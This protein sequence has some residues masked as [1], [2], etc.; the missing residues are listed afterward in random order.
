MNKTKAQKKLTESLSKIDSILA[1][2]DSYPNLED[3]ALSKVQG[4]AN[5][6]LGK[7]FPTQLD[8]AKEILEH[9]VGT[10]V[11]IKIVSEFLV[12]ALPEVEVA[13]KAALLANMNNLGNGCTIDPFIYEKAIKEGIVFDLKQIDL[14]DK[15]S[16]SPLDKKL[17]QYY[18][19]GIE[20][21]ES[22]YDI[23][24]SAIDPNNQ[25]DSSKKTKEG[26]SYLNRAMT[27]S[28]GHYF[29][30]RKRD[31][32]CLLWYMKNKAAYREVWGK[33]TSKS[34]DIFNGG[35]TIT[36][37]LKE[38]GNKETTYY[39]V[40]EKGKLTVWSYGSSW[41]SK[42][43]GSAIKMDEGYTYTFLE[44]KGYYDYVA[45]PTIQKVSRKK[46]YLNGDKIY[47]YD[48]G[49]WGE[50][51]ISTTKYATVDDLPTTTKKGDTVYVDNVL[52]VVT[53]EPKVKKRKRD[54]IEVSYLAN[55]K[56]TETIDV[57][58]DINSKTSLFVDYEM[59]DNKQNIKDGVLYLLTPAFGPK[60]ES[61]KKTWNKVKSSNTEEIIT[62]NTAAQ[63]TTFDPANLY[64]IDNDNDGSYN[65]NSDTVLIGPHKSSNNS[66]DYFVNIQK[67]KEGDNKYTKEFGVVTLEF[68]PRTGNVKQSDGD[69]LQQQ[70]PYDNV[71]HVFF[72]NVKELPD[73]ARTNLEN[74]LKNDSEVNKLGAQV[75]DKLYNIQKAHKKEWEQSEKEWKSVKVWNRDTKKYSF[76]NLDEDK[77][78]KYKKAYYIYRA[79]RVGENGNPSDIKSVLTARSA[80]FQDINKLN[81]KL[82]Q[83]NNVIDRFF[84]KETVFTDIK[85]TK[86]VSVDGKI[87]DMIRWRPMS[88]SFDYET[89]KMFV[90]EMSTAL[91]DENGIFY[92]AGAYAYRAAQIVESDENLLYLS[93]KGMAYPKANQNYY[94]K[95]TLFEFNADYISSL[96]LFDAKVLAAQIITS[97][98]GGVTLS[99]ILGATASWKT[100]YIRDV[101]KDMVEKTIA[102][103]DYTV[104]DCFFTFSNDAYNGMLRAA[105]L[106]EAGLYS[107]HGEEN[108]NNAINPIDLLSNLNYINEAADQKEQINIIEGT[109]TNVSAEISKDVYN[110]NNSLSINTDFSVQ[111]SFIQTMLTNLCTQLVMSMLSPK[112]YLLILINLELFGLTTNFDL[113]S[114]LQNFQALIMSL[115]KSVV[116][117]FMSKLTAKIMEIV[118]ELIAKL[119]PKLAFEQAE[120]YMR[121]LKQIFEHL[122]GLTSCGN[123]S[124]WSQDYIGNADI[125]TSDSQEVT[126]EC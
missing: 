7:L 120:M 70:T 8:F 58:N 65:L 77:R 3:A 125:I 114:F 99:A 106:K 36:E 34:E 101:V 122:R 51:T 11:L 109:L 19:F 123:G 30:G 12:Y 9:L 41:G 2:L 93:A 64:Y 55:V 88:G 16:I 31:F 29:G 40:D 89:F 81:K 115:V 44:G 90:L 68:S 92:S 49:K 72:G 13:L 33:R 25:S 56:L 91:H 112:V 1:A 14:I 97:M 116:D 121:I 35:A 63:I 94:L 42:T 119:I 27:D 15:L 104:S 84:K 73:K 38:K 74:N 86:D 18:Y 21:C 87:E 5:K 61:I 26:T 28:V 4:M 82:E 24:Q 107:Q 53:S 59:V 22:A 50:Q 76:P 67:V 10:D 66:S 80:C 6:Y 103:Q 126:N 111:A 43:E 47:F 96:Q 60:Y 39:E 23:L 71:L 105:E 113:K 46:Y 117:Q 52:Y 78:A 85:S 102:A 100:E 75:I 57:T 98:F 79:F 118:E 69:P 17:G 45:Q 20:N 83:I 108:G 32:D 37:W 95:K 48:N 54:G 62:K 124:D 110:E